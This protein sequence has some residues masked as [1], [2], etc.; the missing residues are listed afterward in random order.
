M[1]VKYTN[2][3]A[4]FDTYLQKLYINIK[5]LKKLR[6]FSKSTLQIS[7]I[8]QGSHRDGRAFLIILILLADSLSDP[9]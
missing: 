7:K 6:A 9:N 8:S 2:N 3:L 1:G 4:T 5:V